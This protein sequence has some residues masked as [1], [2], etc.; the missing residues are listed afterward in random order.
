MRSFVAILCTLPSLLA[1][2]F[3]NSLRADVF[4]YRDAKGETI[5][6]EARLVAAARGFTILETADGQYRIIAD[7][8]ILRREVREGPEPLDAAAMTV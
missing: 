7:E 4:L 1:P 6:V 3:A 8:S 5:E 2:P